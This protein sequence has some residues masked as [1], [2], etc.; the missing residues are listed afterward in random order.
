MDA[1]GVSVLLD[2]M[3]A[4]F[5]PLR[6]PALFTHEATEQAKRLN[7]EAPNSYAADLSDSPTSKL[8]SQ[9]CQDLQASI[10]MDP[11]E[12][13][14]FE[15][16]QSTCDNSEHDTSQTSKGDGGEAFCDEIVVEGIGLRAGH[17]DQ[18]MC[19]AESHA[20]QQDLVVEGL[21]LQGKYPNPFEY[22]EPRVVCDVE[23]YALRQ[24]LVVEGHGVCAKQPN[25]FQG[26]MDSYALIT[27]HCVGHA[28]NESEL[29]DEL[30]ELLADVSPE[31]VERMAE[32]AVMVAE[33]GA[34]ILPALRQMVGRHGVA[35]DES[36]EMNFG[37]TC[38]TSLDGLLDTSLYNQ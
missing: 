10:R 11:P 17:V 15:Q 29:V 35:P 2:E 9:L 33:G 24:D 37:S 8:L 25:P 30:V 26:H 5:S 4:D 18:L 6:K 3:E 1:L 16:D 23:S 31:E 21:G 34:P 28:S 14:S 20:P 22:S 7:Y 38:D 27:Q 19:D 13:D 12:K 32:L 36:Q